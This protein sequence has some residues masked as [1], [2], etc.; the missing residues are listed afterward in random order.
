MA[1]TQKYLGSFELPDRSAPLEMWLKAREELSEYVQ[2]QEVKDL[3][4]LCNDVIALRTSDQARR[5]AG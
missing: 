5:H 2:S 4:E 1:E 3:M